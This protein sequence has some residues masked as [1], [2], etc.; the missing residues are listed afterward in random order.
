MIMRRTDEMEKALGAQRTLQAVRLCIEDLQE[1]GQTD[2][3]LW[4]VASIL[5]THY[6]VDLHSADMLQ[7]A[8]CVGAAA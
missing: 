6:G 8:A 2:V 1:H 4:A 5:E 7:S 3:A